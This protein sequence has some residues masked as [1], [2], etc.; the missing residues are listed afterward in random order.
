[1]N[2]LNKLTVKH[3]KMN[4]KRTLVTI[5]GVILSTA[6]MIGIGLLFSTIRDFAIKETIEYNGKQH[7][8][9]ND[10]KYDQL[11]ILENNDSIKEFY[12]EKGLGFADLKIS[13]NDYKPYIYV[14]S[15]S[16]D[17]LKTLKLIEGRLPAN[18]SEVV[19]SHHIITNGMVPYEVGDILDLNMGIREFMGEPITNNI[20]YQF[21]EDN[22]ETFKVTHN[23]KYKI[24]GIIERPI[25]EDYSAAG[26]SIFTV[27]KDI[28]KDDSINAYIVFKNPR[29]VYEKVQTL[30]KNL[31]LKSGSN[32]PDSYSQINYN[33]SLLGLYGNSKYDNIISSM[34]KV[35][36]IILSLVSIACIIVIY[37]SFAISVM[38]RKKQFGLFS[39]IGATKKQLQKT[40]FYEAFMIGI[41]GIPL[42][43][44]SGFIGIGVVLKIINYLLVK[45]LPYKLIL[46]FY[47][48]FIIIPVLFMIIVIILSA[49]FP[50]RRAS[51]ISPIEAIRLNDDIKINSKKIKTS[52]LVEKIFGVEGEIAL[53]NM[54]RNKKKYRITIISL[55]ISIVLFVS[56]SSFVEYGNR[57]TSEMLQTV[58]FDIQVSLNNQN[59]ELLKKL[60]KGIK[61]LES[62]KKTIAVEG[63]YVYTNS[64]SKN[65]YHN[66]YK[67]VA[68][69]SDQEFNDN[70]PLILLKVDK[71]TY[72]E[73][74]KKLGLKQAKPI[75]LNRFKYI[76]YSNAKR[77]TTSGKL[78]KNVSD[79]KI[80]I[81]VY[82]INDDISDEESELN[83]FNKLDNIVEMN[84]TPFGLLEYELFN[85]P[86]L[87]IPEDMF[88]EILKNRGSIKDYPET[89]VY[90]KIM[91]KSSNT[92]DINKM[93]K[94]YNI[95]NNNFNIYDVVEET[96][97]V[98][99][100]LLVTKILL[101]GFIS[102]V[103]LI[104]V[105]SVFNTINTSMAL[106][107]K[108]F[109]ILRSIGLTP[110]GFDRILKLETLTFGIK[111]LFYALPV[112]LGVILLI[113]LSVGETISF[114]QILI[115]WK[116]IFIAVI[117]VF[118]I[119]AVAM[120]YATKKI[121]QENILEA[122][123][124]ENI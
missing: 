124:V 88:N 52:K 116:A 105:T 46:T 29:A 37:N 57:G 89:H 64:I 34:S 31:G 70:V 121:K 82:E 35:I 98:R 41:I 7:I 111:S 85:E 79:L 102:L 90:Q 62:T 110:K 56:F 19:I 117:G 24:V 76:S 49:Y 119:I 20:S 67:Q 26:Y 4:K 42:G 78:L 107:R 13:E 123:R 28:P 87:I 77:L 9:I 38:E 10:L 61:E 60:T 72:N 96:R 75:L 53:K 32:E 84:D 120:I 80:N 23:E 101:Y 59:D 27:V 92:E 40:V 100:I 48:L 11:K 97:M 33:Y 114:S 86:L 108:E 14:N 39:S 12:Y 71:D 43:I 36:I 73:Y 63:M 44:L 54:K 74:M 94:N 99:N 21:E 109:A 45:I 113:H 68:E 8:I 95:D 2:I 47:P 66:D 6:L 103:T 30:A 115:P 51:K 93:M 55:F 1:M 83:C 118:I 22:V 81:C 65:N 58:D 25:S 69:K 106:R 104:G 5:A 3:L 17:Y 122:I 18:E 16:D 112:S 91:V 15:G 50:A